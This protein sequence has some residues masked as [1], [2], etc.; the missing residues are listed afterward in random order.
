MLGYWLRSDFGGVFEFDCCRVEGEV[1]FIAG[2]V[3]DEDCKVGAAEGGFRVV[4]GIRRWIE[5]E[6]EF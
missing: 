5:D 3:A 1:W 4:C 2:Q 6:G